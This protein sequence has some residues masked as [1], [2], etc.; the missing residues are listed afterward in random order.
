MSVD[1]GGLLKVPKPNPLVIKDNDRR[2]MFRARVLDGELPLVPVPPPI[3]D[4]IYVEDSS[5][6]EGFV[7]PPDPGATVD[8]D[9][10]AESVIGGVVDQILGEAVQSLAAE[11]ACA[12]GFEEDAVDIW[13]LRRR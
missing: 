6:S 1:E 5:S 7:D 4:P 12:V 3:V 10:V 13:E 8:L 11:V 2:R 9:S